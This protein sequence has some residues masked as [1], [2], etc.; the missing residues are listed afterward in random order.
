MDWFFHVLDPINRACSDYCVHFWEMIGTWL[1]A[2]GTIGAVVVSLWLARRSGVVLRVAAGARVLIGG[3][4]G[5]PVEV[6]NITVINAGERE[7]Q[8][9]GVG[10]RSVKRLNKFAFQTSGP[11]GPHFPYRLSAGA[12]VSIPVPINLPDGTNLLEDLA[13]TFLGDNPEADARGMMVQAWTAVGTMVET[14]I[15]AGLAEKLVAA[16]SAVEAR[17]PGAQPD[18]VNR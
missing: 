3:F 15:E 18:G 9:D 8:I 1:A 7:C 13:A 17:N 6:V 2:V 16:K 12:R 5:A 11:T 4:G 14:R 10:W